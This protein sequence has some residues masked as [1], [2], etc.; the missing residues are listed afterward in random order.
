MTPAGKIALWVHRRS[1]SDRL[2]VAVYWII[3]MPWWWIQKWKLWW[4]VQKRKLQ[5]AFDSGESE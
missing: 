2:T 3:V 1:R 5:M 4:W